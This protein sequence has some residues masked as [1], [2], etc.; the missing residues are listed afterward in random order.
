MKKSI[1]EKALLIASQIKELREEIKAEIE[2]ARSRRD[3]I[4][5]FAISRSCNMNKNEQAR[6]DKWSNKIE[7]LET[8]YGTI[9]DAWGY[10]FDFGSFDPA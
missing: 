8:K 6:Y 1:R 9:Y 5:E 3:E 2:K 7:E 10:L 4:E